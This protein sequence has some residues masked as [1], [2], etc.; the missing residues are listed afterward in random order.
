MNE[1][2]KAEAA[3]SQ[4]RQAT[5]EAHELLRDMRET[6]KA[7]RQAGAEMTALL[8]EAAEDQ[9][10]L[11]LKPVID[12]KAADLTNAF[13]S[14]TETAQAHTIEKFEEIT[15]ILLGQNHPNHD[16]TLV[17]LARRVRAA[18]ENQGV[19]PQRPGVYKS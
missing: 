8:A 3:A 2:D 4:L 13:R 1:A 9:V 6:L 18:M 7:L 17:D 16:E 5:R 19:A 14:I 10:D 12:A 11:K 15:A